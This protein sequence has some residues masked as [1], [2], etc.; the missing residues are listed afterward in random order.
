MNTVHFILCLANGTRLALCAGDERAASVV[1]FL[2]RAARLS[3]APGPLPSGVRRL[4]VVTATDR[5]GMLSP[6]NATASGADIVYPLEPTDTLQ[7]RRRRRNPTAIPE[8]LTPEQWL[9]QQLVRLSA[10]IAHAVQPGGLLLHSGLALLP[11]LRGSE[12]GGEGGILFTGRSGV[13][14]STAARRLPPPWSALSDDATLVVRDAAGAHWAHPWPTW[15]RF[16]GREKGDGGD[17]WEV[18]RAAPLRAIFVLEQGAE[19]HVEPLGPGHAVALLTEL[20]L[21]P[22][23]YFLHQLPLDEIAAYN[24]QRFENTCA[25]VQSV[26]AYLLHA[27]LEGAFWEE[28]AQAVGPNGRE[29]C[30]NCTASGSAA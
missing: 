11:S 3:P 23:T 21:Q 18:Q 29:L 30:Q 7:P 25:L 13:G 4:L 28:I 1:N 20:A 6:V 15:S 27:S 19:D 22:A 16:F 17:T 14:K 8:P 10:C 12:A 9:C 5:D 26:P 24:R 2:A